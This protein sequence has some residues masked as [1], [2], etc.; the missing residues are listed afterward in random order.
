[1]KEQEEGSYRKRNKIK[2]I[3]KRRKKLVSLMKTMKKRKKSKGKRN[4]NK[5]G[6]SLLW[7]KRNLVQVQ[8]R[9]S[10]PKRKEN[11]LIQIMRRQSKIKMR[12]MKK[13]QRKKKTLMRTQKRIQLI[14][15]VL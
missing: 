8:Q 13:V 7:T 6:L 10:L 1:M 14:Q 15:M 12:V 9:S 2:S 3:G 4:S 11:N 5:K